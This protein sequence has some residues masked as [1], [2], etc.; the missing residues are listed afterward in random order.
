MTEENKLVAKE[1]LT[2][3]S[4][5]MHTAVS[6]YYVWKWL[7]QARNINIGEEKANQNV[8]LMRLQNTFFHVVS[9]GS[10]YS[11]VI[12]LAIFFDKQDPALSLDKIIPLLDLNEEDKKL[13]EDIRKRQEVNIGKLKT[14][15][16]K[17]I[18][19][20]DIKNVDRTQTSKIIYHESEELFSAV[21]DIFNILSKNITGELF[22]WDH[23]ENIINREMFWLMD[24]LKRGE[25]KRI[26]DIED[27]S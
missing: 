24:N 20:F 11:F 27:F 18:A 8:K 21:Q 6:S 25:D 3:L 19:H 7:E 23:L 22:I 13:I 15:R 4:S 2:Q 17:D 14:I 1:M 26:Q 5:R 10:F 9:R 12:D 16:D